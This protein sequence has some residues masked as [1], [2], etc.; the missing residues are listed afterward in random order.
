[1]KATKN[2]TAAINA[3]HEEQV[4]K[5]LS[6]SKCCCGA[7]SLRNGLMIGFFI[8]IVISAAPRNIISWLQVICVVVGIFCVFKGSK[9]HLWWVKVELIHS[10]FLCAYQMALFGYTVWI[11]KEEFGGYLITSQ[12]VKDKSHDFLM[13]LTAF[14]TLLSLISIA[15][16]C[17]MIIHVNKAIKAMDAIQVVV[18]AR[19]ISPV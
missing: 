10:I 14:W 19:I 11:N 6:D 12:K 1:M 8:I 18:Q 2:T 13:K 15:I 16:Q 5:V 3:S 7:C 17:W 9:V 4:K